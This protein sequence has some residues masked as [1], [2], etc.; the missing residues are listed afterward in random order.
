[1]SLEIENTPLLGSIR[2]LIKESRQLMAVSVNTTMSY[3]YWQIGKKINEEINGQNRSEVY[4]K[5]I[6]ATLWRQLAAEYGTAFSEKNLRRMM[7]FAAIFP[8][9]KNVVSLIRQLSWSQ[10]KILIPIED[11]LKRAFYTEMCQLEKWSVRVFQDRINSMLYERTAISNKSVY[12]NCN[13]QITS[14]KQ[15]SR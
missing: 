8:D 4:G 11:P 1:M 10:I 5:Q 13:G 9:E 15:R 12:R 2:H 7:Q 6:V 14:P 3:L